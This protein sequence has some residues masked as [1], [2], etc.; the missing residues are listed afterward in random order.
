MRIGSW[1]FHDVFFVR[2]PILKKINLSIGDFS[3]YHPIR[4]L[5]VLS[6]VKTHWTSVSNNWSPTW[7]LVMFNLHILDFTRLRQSF[8]SWTAVSLQRWT[9][10]IS[11][12]VFSIGF[13][14]SLCVFIERLC[15]SF[16]LFSRVPNGSAP[17]SLNAPYNFSS[18]FSSA[19]WCFS[20]VSLRTH[21]L[22]FMYVWYHPIC[23]RL[24]F[25]CASLCRWHIK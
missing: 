8:W 20:G 17:F 11:F 18:S 4:N 16:K 3:S 19:S 10:F 25:L 7:I 5:I 15:P 1:H 6:I 12:Y 9:L 2:V 13:S 24:W 22:C 23:P 14:G 21:S